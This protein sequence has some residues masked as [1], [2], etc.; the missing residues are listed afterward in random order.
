MHAKADSR[1]RSA[2]LLKHGHLT[3][4]HQTFKRVKFLVDVKILNVCP[5][6]RLVSI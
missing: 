5:K 4:K 1:S 6:K 2:A 3:L